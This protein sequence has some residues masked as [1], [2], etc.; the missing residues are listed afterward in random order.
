MTIQVCDFCHDDADDNCAECG[1]DLC[2][3]CG[4]DTYDGLFCPD[5]YPD[6]VEEREKEKDEG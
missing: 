1:A 5:C 2:Y 6:Y 4:E 3:S